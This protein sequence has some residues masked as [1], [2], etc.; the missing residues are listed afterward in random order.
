MAD[1]TAPKHSAPPKL[2]AVGES[3]LATTEQDTEEFLGIGLAGEKY[4]VPLAR[5][6]EILTVPPITDVPR[7]PPH[8]LGICSVRGLLVTVMDLRLRLRLPAAPAGP[9][10]RVLLTRTSRDEVVGLFVDV[11]YSVLRLRRDQIELASAAFGSDVADHVTGVG[12]PGGNEV[13]VLLDMES[14]AG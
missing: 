3:G 8:V 9:L 12:R 1:L 2:A 11:V 7:S 14:V 6:R 4:A 5:V 10:S 13:I